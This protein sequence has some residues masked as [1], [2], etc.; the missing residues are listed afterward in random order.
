MS[1]SQNP[2]EVV[3]VAES[4]ETQWCRSGED[5]STQ[6]GCSVFEDDV[7]RPSVQRAG[8]HVA[9]VRDWGSSVFEVSAFTQSNAALFASSQHRGSQ[10]TVSLHIKSMVVPL[11]KALR[12]MIAETSNG[13]NVINQHNTSKP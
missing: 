1:K 6:L 11:T 8:G 10:A 12:V 4:L 3:R 9:F 13:I 5:P 2:E 7:G